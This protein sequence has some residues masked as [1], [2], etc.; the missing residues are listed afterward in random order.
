MVVD[1]LGRIGREVVLTGTAQVAPVH[2][3]GRPPAS[4]EKLDE[5]HLQ[6][7]SKYPS[8]NQ[9]DVKIESVV[10][11]AY[12][13]YD[14]SY[15][16]ECIMPLPGKVIHLLLVAHVLVSLGESRIE[17]VKDGDWQNSKDQVRGYNQ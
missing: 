2:V 4:A 10:G 16:R 17:D 12:F 5:Q 3:L 13:F 14:G 11:L 8:S 15:V 7:F 6:L 1:A 9:V